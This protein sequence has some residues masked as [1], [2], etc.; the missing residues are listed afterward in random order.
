MADMETHQENLE[1]VSLRIAAAVMQFCR[2][3]LGWESKLFHADELRNYVTAATGI[4]APAS[5][6]RVLR[7]LR[8]KRQLDYEVVSRRESLYK[9]IWVRPESDGEPPEGEPAGPDGG[10]SLMPQERAAIQSALAECEAI[11]EHNLKGF[12]ETAQA[13]LRIRDERLYRLTYKTFEAY[14]RKRWNWGHSHAYRQIE[15]ARVVANLSPMGDMPENERQVRPLASLPPEAQREVWD[16]AVKA[17]PKGKVTEKAV[18]EQARAHFAQQRSAPQAADSKRAPDSK[19]T[20]APR[21]PKEPEAVFLKRVLEQVTARLKEADVIGNRT[22]NVDACSKR[23]LAQGLYEVYAAMT[24]RLREFQAKP[25]RNG[26]SAQRRKNASRREE[27]MDLPPVGELE[28]NDD[29]ASQFAAGP[30]N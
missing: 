19:R 28:V 30:V 7:D 23:A 20:P 25:N 24:Q 15:A 21:G 11:I 13:V 17:S 16:A 8:Q 27:A 22:W 4:N 14:C 5:A 2:E 18:R 1:R 26:Q 9:I 6:D 12:V 29:T 3:R 10:G